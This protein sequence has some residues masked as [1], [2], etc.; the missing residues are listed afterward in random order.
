MD[1]GGFIEENGLTREQEKTFLDAY[2][3][4]STPTEAKILAFSKAYRITAIVGWFIERLAQLREGKKVF[5]AADQGEYEKK[6]A[7]KIEHVKRL[8]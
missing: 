4:G 3:F 6:L 8:L 7:A 1:L 5:V 2:G